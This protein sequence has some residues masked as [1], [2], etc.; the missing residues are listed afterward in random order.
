[1]GFVVNECL[2]RSGGWISLFA[3]RGGGS[4][5]GCVV[6]GGAVARIIVEIRSVQDGFQ[7]CQENV[8]RNTKKKRTEVFAQVWKTCL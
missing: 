6:S 1:M 4:V 2:G 7:N 5:F 3:A 8:K